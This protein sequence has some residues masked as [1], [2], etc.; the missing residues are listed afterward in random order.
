MSQK[1]GRTTR[2]SSPS[3]SRPC[4]A[5][6]VPSFIDR[7]ANTVTAMLNKALQQTGAGAFYFMSHMIGFGGR[8]LPAP[9]A[10]LGR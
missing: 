9:V 1:V 7:I 4:V 10:N 8:T 6:A 2:L 3:L 5:K